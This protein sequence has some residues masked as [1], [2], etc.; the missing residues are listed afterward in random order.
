[1][2]NDN[3]TR[4]IVA[5]TRRQIEVRQEVHIRAGSEHISPVSSEKLLG[6]RVHESLKWK[7]HVI[8]GQGAMAE[9]LGKRVTAVKRVSKHAS[10]KTLLQIH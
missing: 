4:L 5:G 9:I 8:D 7:S 3:K 1:M 10:F 2:I 6:L